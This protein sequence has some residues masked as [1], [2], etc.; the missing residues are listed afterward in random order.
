MTSRVNPKLRPE[1]TSIYYHCIVNLFAIYIYKHA[2]LQQTEKN[3]HIS[4]LDV[5]T[6]NQSIHIQQQVQHLDIT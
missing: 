2:A 1:D 3:S 5:S 4:K 6:V